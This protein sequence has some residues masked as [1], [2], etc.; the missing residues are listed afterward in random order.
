MED[1]AYA[2]TVRSS[3]AEH[4]NATTLRLDRDTS[5]GRVS[6]ESAIQELLIAR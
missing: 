5:S 4:H 2:T 6:S 3:T 1:V